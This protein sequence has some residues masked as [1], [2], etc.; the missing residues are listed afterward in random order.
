MPHVHLD[1]SRPVGDLSRCHSMHHLVVGRVDQLSRA[2]LG[3]RA[4]S[5]VSCLNRR[6]VVW[7]WT[8]LFTVGFNDLYVRLCSMGVWSD[9][10]IF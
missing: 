4:Y 5:C 10:R 2:P 8:S 1:Y 3:L 9:I 7:A 6:H